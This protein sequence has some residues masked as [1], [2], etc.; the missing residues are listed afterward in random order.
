[1]RPRVRRR[2]AQAEIAGGNR[3]MRLTRP[4][5]RAVAGAVAVALL[6]LALLLVR[7]A[8]TEVLGQTAPSVG[9]VTTLS[10]APGATAAVG[11]VTVSNEASA[12]LTVQRFA[13]QLHVTAPPSLRIGVAGA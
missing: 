2:N 9:A 6:A 3:T 12:P 7:P 4:A 11:D 10:L 1:M 5:E 8:P 13:L